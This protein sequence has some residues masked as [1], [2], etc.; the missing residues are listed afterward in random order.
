MYLR[1]SRLSIENL[2]E[3]LL[4][5]GE[6]FFSH[7]CGLFFHVRE[8]FLEITVVCNIALE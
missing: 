7:V 8:I 2:W 3:V 5:L 4:F 1:V 6:L